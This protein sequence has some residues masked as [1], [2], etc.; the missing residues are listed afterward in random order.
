MSSRISQNLM[1]M[2]LLQVNYRF[3]T[4]MITHRVFIDEG[5]KEIDKIRKK[6]A[7]GLKLDLPCAKA[8]K[9]KAI[10][11]KYFLQNSNC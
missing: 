3:T 4:V 5:L 8:N 11:K 7:K 1:N 6:I 9:T 10:N 2:L